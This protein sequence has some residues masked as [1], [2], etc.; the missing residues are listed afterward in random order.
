MFYLDTY[1][2]NL[3]LNDNFKMFYDH[4]YIY[5]MFTVLGYPTAGQYTLRLFQ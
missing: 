1:T 3:E 5:M 2:V 4:I